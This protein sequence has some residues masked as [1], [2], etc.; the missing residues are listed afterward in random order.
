MLIQANAKNLDKGYEISATFEHQGIPYE[1]RFAKIGHFKSKLR[2]SHDKF[3]NAVD[4]VAMKVVDRGNV[5]EY[6]Q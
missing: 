3:L 4:Y 2:R 5:K 6:L 1:E